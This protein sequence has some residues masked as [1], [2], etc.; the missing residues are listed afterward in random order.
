MSLNIKNERTHTLVRELAALSG[1]SQTEAVTDAVQRRL[2]ELQVPGADR[3]ARID[4]VL[5]ELRA[6]LS[7]ADREALRRAGADL[8]DERGLP[9]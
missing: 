4:T 8:Y 5:A 9:W 7:A 1:V 2:R 6:G 3:G